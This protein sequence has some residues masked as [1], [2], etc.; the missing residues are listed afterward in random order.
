MSSEECAMILHGP[1]RENFR[2]GGDSIYD[3]RRMDDTKP[4]LIAADEISRALPHINVVAAMERAFVA[5]SE[6]RAVVPPVGE[7][8]FEKPPGDVHIKYGYVRGE[9]FYVIKVASGFYENPAL[10]LSSSDGLML[11]FRQR[12]GELAAILLDEGRLTDVRTAAAGAACAKHLAPREVRCIGIVGTGIQARLQLEWLKG[13]VTCREAVV[14][15]RD[16]D[17]LAACAADMTALGFTIVLTR[18]IRRLAECCN[19]IVTTTPSREALLDASMIRPGT[20]ITAVGAD[21]P[22]K[23]ELAGDV[24]RR[25]D[26]VV[27]DSLAQ[28]RVRGEIARAVED[29]LFDMSHAVELGAVIAGRAAGRRD[30][31]QITVADLTGVAVQD[32]A[33]AQEIFKQVTGR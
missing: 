20:H 2:E 23:R 31:R 7:L 6:G 10:G 16:D 28:C 24:L 1:W 26:V 4:R 8:E 5:Y 12:T 9:E 18:D 19:L 32:M 13:V 15:G 30:D 22:S 29:G 17:R 14:W 3:A 11:L 33:I 21:A 25:A 27:A